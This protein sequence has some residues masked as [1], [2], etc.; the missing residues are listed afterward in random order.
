MNNEIRLSHILLLLTLLLS[1][2][3]PLTSSNGSPQGDAFQSVTM[4]RVFYAELEGSLQDAEWSPDGKFLAVS[5]AAIKKGSTYSS[6][7][8][9]FSNS[10]KK[11][12]EKEGILWKPLAWSTRELLAVMGLED[13]EMG[14]HFLYLFKP[15]G[16]LVM[17]SQP[18]YFDDSSIYWY[19][20]GEI[21]G[22]DAWNKTGGSRTFMFSDRGLIWSSEVWNYGGIIWGSSTSS[23]LLLAYSNSKKSVGIVES[24]ALLVNPSGVKEIE[25]TG[26]NPRLWVGWFS[27]DNSKFLLIEYFKEGSNNLKII[28]RNGSVIKELRG[29]VP[30]YNAWHPNSDE[31]LL[32]NISQYTQ[33]FQSSMKEIELLSLS[34]G[35]LWKKGYKC[36]Y[37]FG[38]WSKNGSYL[39][40]MVHGLKGDK[41]YAKLYMYSHSGSLLWNRTII[42]GADRITD[43]FLHRGDLIWKPDGPAL[44]LRL[45]YKAEGK[46]YN[47]AYLLN[48]KG[49]LKW[50]EDRVKAEIA[51]LRDSGIVAYI[52]RGNEP[53]YV[54]VVSWDGNVKKIYSDMAK[55]TPIWSKNG[56][57][58]AVWYNI[59]VKVK[60]P[61]IGIVA[62]ASHVN[63]YSLSYQRE[64]GSE[65]STAHRTSSTTRTQTASPRGSSTSVSVITVT[66]VEKGSEGHSLLKLALIFLLVAI[67]VVEILYIFSITRSRGG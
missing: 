44:A 18:L 58:L 39:A 37:P 36:L 10:G 22:V 20:N 42:G 46:G 12:F 6:K 3:L 14:R 62:K 24:R 2:M 21:L 11:L 40:M 64:M 8:V 29:K 31:L 34:R 9:V 60:D 17:K 15:N 45:E 23:D 48:E 57:Q 1:L 65:T 16:E 53:G 7:L 59:G 55:G 4:K 66:K 26:G 47:S 54:V 28:D 32:V 30:V 35:I 33:N 5:S 63:V 61:I 56:D 50:A 67:I 41:R 19:S 27:P 38:V 51:P 52:E 25:K 49:E 13:V 43:P